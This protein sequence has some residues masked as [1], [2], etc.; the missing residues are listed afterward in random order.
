MKTYYNFSSNK[1]GTLCSTVYTDLTKTI[2]VPFKDE[3]NTEIDNIIVKPEE[4]VFTEPINF[5]KLLKKKKTQELL[6]KD[7][8]KRDE[9]E[10][11]FCWKNKA[12]CNSCFVRP[13]YSLKQVQSLTKKDLIEELSKHNHP[14][15]RIINNKQR[16]VH[17]TRKELLDHYVNVHFLK[18]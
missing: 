6:I 9:V 10:E 13:I 16:N 14:K 18:C 2:L 15:N 5:V 11:I 17:Q 12:K 3:I 4:V 7:K 1:D 8:S